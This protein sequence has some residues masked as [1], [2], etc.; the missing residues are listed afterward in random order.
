MQNEVGEQMLVVRNHTFVVTPR[1]LE[2]IVAYTKY[3]RNDLARK[4]REYQVEQSTLAAA[5]AGALDTALVSSVQEEIQ[6]AEVV[7]HDVELLRDELQHIY[8]WHF[9]RL[10][11]VFRRTRLDLQAER[12]EN[13]HVAKIV[14]THLMQMLHEE[15]QKFNREKFIEYINK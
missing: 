13:I 6:R 2:A 5:G 15:N 1:M 10:A 3:F 7:M 14:L 4:L 9:E 8:R 12:I 11:E